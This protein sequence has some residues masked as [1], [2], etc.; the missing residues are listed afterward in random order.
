[1]TLM[2]SVLHLDR[3]AI[4]ALRIT[5]PYSLH[6]V[7][8][9]LY[10]DTRSQEAKAASEFSGILY[11][12]RG[13][14]FQGRKILLLADRSPADCIDGQYGEVRSK[15]IPN[16]FLMHSQYRFKVVVNPTRRD[17]ASGK[18]LPIKGR[19]AISDWFCE[20]APGWGFHASSE[21]LQVDRLDV[22]RFFS[23]QQHLVT[24]AQ[25]HIQGSL[26]VNDQ[27]LFRTS[28]RRGIGRGRAFGC[29]L[30]QIVPLL[31]N[32]FA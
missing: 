6:R 9:S 14:D 17:S 19:E 26:Q 1:M 16:D 15:P 3:R 18:L 13:G 7:V 24:L 2:A 12:D 5:D 4:K 29:G 20:R 28:F 11:A 27:D 10:K 31:D 30:L 25:A 22:L 23:K 8:Y 32:P 21:H